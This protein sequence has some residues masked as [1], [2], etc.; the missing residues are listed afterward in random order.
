MPSL[1]PQLPSAIGLE[2]GV[3]ARAAAEPAQPA[4]GLPAPL[5]AAP[6][7]AGPPPVATGGSAPAVPTLPAPPATRSPG[8]GPSGTRKIRRY[9]RTWVNVREARARGAA[10]VLVLRPGEAVVV[11]SLRRG[12]Y[13]VLADG[14]P[15]GYVHRSNLDSG[16]TSTQP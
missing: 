9:A 2:S 15:V 14:A 5:P 11:D 4:R 13:R 3:D 16:P 6:L 10:A 12:W 7:P 1:R 8:P